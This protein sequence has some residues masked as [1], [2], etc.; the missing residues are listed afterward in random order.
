MAIINESVTR[1]LFCSCGL[2]SIEVF[3]SYTYTLDEVAIID[4]NN[5]NLEEE[6]TVYWILLP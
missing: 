1:F 3:I 2:K 4:F 5:F 6:N